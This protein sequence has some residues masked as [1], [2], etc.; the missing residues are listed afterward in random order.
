MEETDQ[1]NE[2]SSSS[3]SISNGGRQDGE[4]SSSHN[5]GL[6]QKSSP[7]NGDDAQAARAIA[8]RSDVEAAIQPRAA[9]TTTAVDDDDDAQ[10][11]VPTRATFEVPT[12]PS[13]ASSRG[14]DIDADIKSRAR[15]QVEGVA[16]A[17]LSTS[18]SSVV[19]DSSSAPPARASTD[20]DDIK[21]RARRI[22]SIGD[23]KPGAVS[24]GNNVRNLPSRDSRKSLARS[25]IGTTTTVSVS[26]DRAAGKIR[27]ASGSEHERRLVAAVDA[28]DED[29]PRLSEESD[30]RENEKAEALKAAI[31]ALE[32]EEETLVE[33]EIA[34][35]IEAAVNDAV[36]RAVEE[37]LR[38]QVSQHRSQISEPQGEVVATAYAEDVR[39]ASEEAGKLW[40]APSKVCYGLIAF[41]VAVAIAAG[42]T[43]GVILSNNDNGKSISS[44]SGGISTPT[45]APS[46]ATSR[47]DIELLA[48]FLL[49][50][51]DISD[52]KEKDSPRY[53]AIEWLVYDDPRSLLIEDNST[54]QFERFSLASLYHSTDGMNWRDTVRWLSG[55]SHCN[56]NLITCENGTVV[57]MSFTQ[58][59]VSGPL[60]PEIGNFQNVRGIYFGKN[61]IVGTI[62][63]EIGLLTS[64]TALQLWDNSIVG[65]LPTEIGN[66]RRLESFSVSQNT[67]LVGLVP[68]EIG[69]LSTLTSLQL[70]DNSFD[71][72]LPIEITRLRNLTSLGVSGNLFEGTIHTEFGMLTNLSTLQL[73][74]NQ[75]NGPI[76]S[77]LGR[78][79]DALTDMGL[80][81]NKLSGLVPTELGVFTRLSILSLHSN[82][83]Q[84]TLP[85]EI[86]RLS[87]LTYLN[88]GVNTGMVGSIPT[89]LGGLS[90]LTYLDCSDSSITGTV[91][92]ELGNMSLLTSLDVSSNRLVGPIPSEI[93]NMV[94]LRVL[95][96]FDNTGLTGTLPTEVRQLK[97]I[98][99]AYFDSTSLTGGLVDLAF[100]KNRDSADFELWSDCGGVI[101]EIRCQCCTNCCDAGGAGCVVT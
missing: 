60:P 90:L 98:V 47:L 52:L 50:G 31:G 99:T 58:N 79:S 89:E 95:S 92:S 64:A 80:S 14:L 7:I 18:P 35:D 11:H 54:E 88:V 32:E 20:N 68:S 91:P 17:P 33:A 100:C 65:T 97:F 59:S 8:R 42:T 57:E 5:G 48:N 43:A 3:I 56:W 62:P 13:N 40:G 4:K 10:P 93:G 46:S 86:G 37:T 63:T 16:E 66:L 27:L 85:T 94:Q 74:K 82:E 29:S 81:Q 12:I 15:R 49:P 61:S 30:S 23:V 101:P 26:R 71:G 25:N 70:W 1:P 67:E 21:V 24:V 34:P 9:T 2:K 69:L 84:G 83:L 73:F 28:S 75:F 78:L 51:V 53:R 45:A 55:S 76:P 77:E 22:E 39:E 44:S 36:N 6:E 72:E 41:V 87:L 96:F 38:S 19:E